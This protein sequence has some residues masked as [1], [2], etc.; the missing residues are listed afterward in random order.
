MY[1]CTHCP[2]GFN[3]ASHLEVPTRLH[4]GTKLHKCTVCEWSFTQPGHL[5]RHSLTHT[6]KKRYICTKSIN[7]PGT[8]PPIV[9][10]PPLAVLAASISCER[11][12]SEAGFI[13]NERRTHLSGYLYM[14]RLI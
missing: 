1:K 11:V 6:V 8:Q 2:K 9:V 12:F 3:Q 14:L 13:L 7:V 4:T 10:P 5:Q